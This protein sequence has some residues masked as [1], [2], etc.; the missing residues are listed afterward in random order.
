MPTH[1]PKIHGIRCTFLQT[2]RFKT[3]GLT[4]RF[5]APFTP[6]TINNRVLLPFVLLEGTKRFPTKQALQTHTDLLFGT[7]ISGQTFRLGRESVVSFSLRTLSDSF[8]PKGDSLVEAA[9]DLLAEVIYQPK[10]YRGHLRSLAVLHQK[11]LLKENLEGDYNDKIEY[12]SRRLSELMFQGELYAWNDKGIL[13][14]FGQLTALS[15][16]SAY[17]AMLENDIVEISVI[18]EFDESKMAE[19]IRSKFAPGVT[20]RPL[21]IVD[22]E[23][24]QVLEIARVT[25]TAVITQAKVNVGYRVD[26]LRNH[27]G[28]KAMVLANA[29]LGRYDFS[30]LFKAVREARQLCYYVQ[31]Y[32]Q[33]NKGFFHVMAG[34]A[35][36]NVDAALTMIAEQIRL[37]QAGTFTDELLTLAKTAVIDSIRQDIDKPGYLVTSEFIGY[38]LFDQPLDSAV[39]LA[40]YAAVS[41]EDIINAASRIVTDTIYV[42]TEAGTS[43]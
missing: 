5:I 14:D 20:P 32:Y 2:N 3:I 38:H 23:Q 12:A 22:T 11:R 13:E 24:K 36:Q 37:L 19:M 31:S 16:D 17:H 43:A 21:A 39:E 10:T 28:F 29:M 26:V 8:A 7:D 40:G 4:V 27:P 15:V 25:E 42:L 6:E 30:L 18:G 33:S 9:I 1:Y 41:R 34:V 35:P